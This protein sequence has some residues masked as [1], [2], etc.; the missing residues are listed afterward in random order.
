MKA[1]D[2][3]VGVLV[4]ALG[5]AVVGL[6][7]EATEQ[8]LRAQQEERWLLEDAMAENVVRVTGN[9]FSRWEFLSR[10]QRSTRTRFEDE[11]DAHVDRMWRDSTARFYLGVH[12]REYQKTR[13]GYRENRRV[14]EN[15]RHP[16]RPF[17]SGLAFF[18][19]FNSRG[20][21]TFGP[22]STTAPTGARGEVLT[23]TRASAATCTKT[24]SGGLATTGIA[25][26]DL[27][28]LSSNVARVEY[29]SAG[30][31]GLLVEAARTNSLVRSQ[32]IDHA[33]WTKGG[34]I[35]TITAD[36]ATAPDGT[37]T[38]DRYQ[39][40]NTNTDYVLQTFSVGGLGASGSVYLKGTSGAGTLYLCRGGAASQCVTC[41]YVAATWSRCRYEATLATSSNLF[42]GCDTGTLGAACAQTG[43]DVL[44]WGLQGE[45]GAYATSYIPT[46]SAAVTRA[47]EGGSVTIASTPILSM[48]GT[49]QFESNTLSNGRII[50]AYTVAANDTDRF[51]LL[52]SGV[53][54][55][56]FI[57][58]GGVS[59]TQASATNFTMPG[60]NRAAVWLAS[61]ATQNTIANGTANSA[62][63]ARTTV[64]ATTLY[65]GRYG[66]GVSNEPDAI[67]TKLCADPDAARC[68]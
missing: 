47:A 3:L 56:N 62:A 17:S 52:I 25:D 15:E 32:E 64:T 33:G 40:T 6:A 20:M 60:L 9:S 41:S 2:L 67:L 28:S 34:A 42:V 13:Q 53:Q 46:T 45:L 31:L 65:I 24:A 66:G 37:L 55:A 49:S 61:G 22:C 7:S 19:A 29:D 4:F 38:A 1:L 54:P 57:A 48:A 26:G 5:M 23:F 44:V 39:Y 63:T 16:E 8:L 14:R 11:M 59:T 30:T 12:I 10:Q 43:M 50:E 21:G 35:G 51:S 36:Y 68:R 58:N 18:E 27:V